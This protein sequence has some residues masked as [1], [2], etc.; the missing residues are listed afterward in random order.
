LILTWN[1][2]LSYLNSATAAAV[3]QSRLPGFAPHKVP[4]C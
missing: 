3:V 4:L 2:G 1:H